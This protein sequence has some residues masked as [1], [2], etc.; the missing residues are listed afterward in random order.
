MEVSVFRGD[1]HLGFE[2][3]V[4]ECWDVVVQRGV[5]KLKFLLARA[6]LSG[7]VPS[8]LCLSRTSGW[9]CPHFCVMTEF[10]SR[11][12]RDF[13]F[14]G[15]SELLL[16]GTKYLPRRMLRIIV[17]F[18]PYNVAAAALNQ[19]RSRSCIS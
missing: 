8:P 7:V 11:R 9:L 4:W 17:L 19:R 15:C 10:S 6:S 18:T 16:L 3:S 12:L 13:G 14:E 2:A 1:G 5:R